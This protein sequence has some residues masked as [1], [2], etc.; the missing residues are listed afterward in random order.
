MSF[1]DDKLE[2]KMQRRKFILMVIFLIIVLWFC[3]VLADWTVN[4]VPVRIVAIE[5]GI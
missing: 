2:Q 1:S 3:L 4:G 5:G